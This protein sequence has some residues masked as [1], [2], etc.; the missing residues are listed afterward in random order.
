[1]EFEKV[2][3]TYAFYD[4]FSCQIY[5]AFDTIPQIGHGEWAISRGGDCAY[6]LRWDNITQT[7]FPNELMF[8]LDYIPEDIE[9]DGLDE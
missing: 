4:D 3:C 6:D 8:L 7:D 1:M 2:E 5:Y 9:I